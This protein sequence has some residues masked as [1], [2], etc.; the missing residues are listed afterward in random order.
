M[1]VTTPAALIDHATHTAYSDPGHFASLLDAVPT[2]LDALS[3]VVRNVIVH[4]RASDHVLP[5]HT[6]GDIHSRWIERA[7]DL[8][9]QRHPTQLAETREPTTK[10]QGCCRDH[11]LLSVAIPRQ[12]G[13]PARSRI[14]FVD[15][16][17]DGWHNDHVIPEMWSGERWVRFDPEFEAATDSLP[18]PRDIPVGKGFQTAAEVWRGHRAGTLDV[19]N[20]GVDAAMPIARGAWFVRDYVVLEVAHRFGDEL[21]LW[22]TWGTMTGPDS[23]DNDM[24]LIDTV[25]ALLVAADTGDLA[26]EQRLLD[27]YRADERLH[28][29]DTVLRVDL[30]DQT[31]VTES[32]TGRGAAR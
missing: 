20:Y 14:G 26:A 4:Y 31:L 1:T 16:F 8:D 22:D 11:T 28:P 17:N 13:I 15:Y 9:Q 10:V 32:L 23:E 18:T 27:L 29:G 5:A 21:L 7:L 24:E 12:H 6:V 19:D 2:E 30:L 25:S 3:S